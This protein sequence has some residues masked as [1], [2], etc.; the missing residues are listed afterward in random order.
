MT[1]ATF[2]KYEPKRC[3]DKVHA[4]W[5]REGGRSKMLRGWLV[6]KA[7]VLWFSFFERDKKNE[8]EGK[9]KARQENRKKGIK[10]FITKG[11]YKKK[12][13]FRKIIK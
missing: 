9:E 5:E 12:N 4:L 11:K 1:C 8:R 2:R 3:I 10:S 6:Y 13:K 7:K